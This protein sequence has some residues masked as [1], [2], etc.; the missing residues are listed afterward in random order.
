MGQALYGFTTT[1]KGE[2]VRKCERCGAEYKPNARNQKYCDECK[3]RRIGG[4]RVKDRMRD[5]SN[6]KEEQDGEHLR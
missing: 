2:K 1:R 6:E 5:W 3:Y 4:R